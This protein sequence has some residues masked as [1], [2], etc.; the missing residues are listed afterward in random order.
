MISGYF[1]I[2]VLWATGALK[3]GMPLS[4]QGLLK[5]AIERSYERDVPVCETEPS[6][7]QE[8]QAE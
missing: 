6:Y 4:S 8:G 2:V 5:A 3:E 7:K 1:T